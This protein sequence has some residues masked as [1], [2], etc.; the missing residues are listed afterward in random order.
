[1]P[2][3]CFKI[4][5]MNIRQFTWPI[6]PA[7]RTHSCIA[8]WHSAPAGPPTSSHTSTSSSSQASPGAA[9]SIPNHQQHIQHQQQSDAGTSV[10]SSTSMA[11]SGGP[12]YT[13]TGSSS[14]GS[15]HVHVGADTHVGTGPVRTITDST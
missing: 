8:K 1:M 4:L 14:A 12:T 15:L 5:C 9:S 7:S 6:L 11:N 3:R 2:L 10:S 13:R